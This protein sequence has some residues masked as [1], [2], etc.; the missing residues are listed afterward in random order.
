M[1]FRSDF[2]TLSGDLNESG[3]N[4]AAIQQ[5]LSPPMGLFLTSPVNPITGS[6][7]TDPSTAPSSR[8]D[9]IMPCGPLFSNIAS[10]QV[11]RSEVLSPMPPGLTT[12][13]STTASDHLAVLMAFNNP[14][15][16]NNTAPVFTATPSTTTVL[17]LATLVLTNAATDAQA[18]PQTLAYAVTVTNLLYGGL[19]TNNPATINTNTGV[20]TW[21]P[22]VAQSPTTNLIT[23]VVTDSGVPSLSAT[24]SFTVIVNPPPP[25][26]ITSVIV[27]TNSITLGWIAPSYEQF[28]MQ[29][30]SNLAQ[31]TFWMDFTNIITPTPSGSTN[32]LFIDDG[33]Q[34]GGFLDPQR[35]YRLR[36]LP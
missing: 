10:S 33:T 19:V 35:F 30:A 11:F 6:I 34:T 12:N 14:D 22:S 3:T 5:L 21:T 17:A 23:T 15:G 16:T 20:I 24:N 18:P 36:L 9:Y 29:W 2:Y 28:M 25:F 32:F 31:P 1:L 13:D 7:N 27:G 26:N 8:I 4:T